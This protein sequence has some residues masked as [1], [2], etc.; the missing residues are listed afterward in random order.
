MS[1]PYFSIITPVYNREKVIVPCLESVLNQTFQ[2]FEVIAIN[3]GST[4]ATIERLWN[5]RVKRADSRLNFITYEQNKGV[6]YARNRGIEAAK[7][8]F[9]LFLDSDDVLTSPESLASIAEQIHL[10][11][12]YKHY[13][14]RVDDR[15]H[16]RSLPEAPFEY[17]YTD[18]L[19]G[20][21]KGDYAHVITPDS[22][23]GKLFIEDFRTYESL[24]WL[25]VIKD[26]GRQLYLPLTMISRD[27]H[28]DD[29]LTK[30][31]SSSDE[32]AR[33]K[34][35]HYLQQY[36]NW[37]ADDFRAAGLQEALQHKVRNA[38]LLGVA[39]GEIEPTRTIIRRYVPSRIQ[40]FFYNSLISPICGSV[41]AWA[42][43][44]RSRIKRRK[45][46][47]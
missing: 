1:A 29:S 10:R 38:V 43:E 30:E 12:G 42:I 32:Q 13:L 41:L 46:H 33:R 25:R 36:L 19:S 20:K 28:R 8:K 24:N 4:D 44:T 27:R 23:T 34:R 17:T 26:L 14:F 45:A 21:A 3:D 47:K 5:L 11:P 40:Q 22:F 31:N 39:L 18:W 9:I 15:D 35:F 7:G 2:D 16:D 6:N 37:Y